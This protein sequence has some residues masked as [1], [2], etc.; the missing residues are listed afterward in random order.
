MNKS[1]TNSNISKSVAKAAALTHVKSVS[2]AVP[3]IDVPVNITNPITDST[4]SSQYQHIFQ[5]PERF[6]TNTLPKKISETKTGSQSYSILSPL[7]SSLKDAPSPTNK[8]LSRRKNP[9]LVADTVAEKSSH[10]H[11]EKEKEKKNS[12]ENSP[13]SSTLNSSSSNIVSDTNE[14]VE[15]TP[16]PST[17]TSRATTAVVNPV[18]PI[19]GRRRSVFVKRKGV[20]NQTDKVKVIDKNLCKNASQ[21]DVG[22]GSGSVDHAVIKND[23]RDQTDRHLQRFCR[24]SSESKSFQGSDSSSSSTCAA[25][26]AA[27]ISQFNIKKP[28]ELESMKISSLNQSMSSAKQ[29]W[30]GINGT[31]HRSMRSSSCIS[32]VRKIIEDGL[33]TSS[34][35]ISEDDDDDDDDDYSDDME[36]EEDEEAS[37]LESKNHSQKSSELTDDEIG[38]EEGPASLKM[39]RRKSS[40][41]V[42]TDEKRGSWRK[43]PENILKDNRKNISPSHRV[44]VKKEDNKR[45]QLSGSKNTSFRNNIDKIVSR[46]KEKVKEI[47]K[48]VVI[49][50][51]NSKDKDNLEEVWYELIPPEGINY[52]EH[53]VR[54]EPIHG[55]TIIGYLLPG[56]C[57]VTLA[58]AGIWGKVQCHKKVCDI[59]VHNVRSNKNES[60]IWGWCL[61]ED[62]ISKH[63][64]LK[65]NEIINEDIEDEKD[66]CQ[67][68]KTI[69]KVMSKKSNINVVHIDANKEKKVAT[70]TNTNKTSVIKQDVE[71]IVKNIRINN[72]D[73]WQEKLDDEGGYTYFYNST[74]GKTSW[75]APEWVEET[76][77]ESGYK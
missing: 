25:D 24:K 54:L 23:D 30:G 51:V 36:V 77:P 44:R 72:I 28:A 14:R 60:D 33:H 73:T 71:P 7:S 13:P 1:S 38:E 17:V 67:S 55:S 52:Y 49:D 45:F 56:T 68:Q 40:I 76:D 6:K 2:L 31:L 3:S 69:T 35:V 34:T 59:G 74:T 57:V 10:F 27:A 19:V 15:Y 12:V 58:V 26:I 32:D 9:N 70:L 8:L 65:S 4:L 64:F 75:E 39:G 20:T 41:Y 22:S 48:E 5:K 66:I 21:S 11:Q 46:G 16:C 42:P 47:K 53:P 18:S 29:A 37:L 62:K 50:E 61:L 63:L 43:D